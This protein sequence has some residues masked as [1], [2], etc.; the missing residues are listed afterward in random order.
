MHKFDMNFCISFL[1]T[2]IDVLDLKQPFQLNDK[3]LRALENKTHMRASI[4]TNDNTVCLGC[5]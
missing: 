4:L 2:W 3:I 5:G 1:Y